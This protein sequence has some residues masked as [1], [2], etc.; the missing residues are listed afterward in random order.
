MS[1][2]NVLS[3]TT[4]GPTA[5]R[6]IDLQPAPRYNSRMKLNPS[7]L[8]TALTAGLLLGTVGVSHG[9]MTPVRLRVAYA[10]NPIGID[11]VQPNLSWQAVA[12]TP[13]AMQSAYEILVASSPESLA[14]DRGD[15]WSTGKVES[16]T[17]IQVRYAGR[18][19]ATHARAYWK[20][21]VW[22][23]A[24]D[25]SDWSEPAYWEMG[26]R[27]PDEFPADW[28]GAELPPAEEPPSL[29]GCH[30][31]WHA[32]DA[33]ADGGVNAPSG[34]RMFRRWIEVPEDA[35]ITRARIL[36]DADDFFRLYVNGIQVSSDDITTRTWQTL[37]LID[38]NRRIVPG[39]NLLA[40]HTE[41]SGNQSSAGLIGRVEVDLADGASMQWD[42]DSSWVSLASEP[43][44]W[45]QPA[46]TPAENEQWT[47]AR[48]VA[49]Y[50]DAP[51]GL[52][53]D[54]LKA[55]QPAPHL[56]TEFALADKPVAYATLTATALGVYEC[57]LNGARVGE[58][59]MTPG[60]TDYT[61][62]IQYQAYDVTPL[63]KPGS[64]NAL[65]ALLGDG[66]YVG[67]IAHVGRYQYGEYPLR[68]KAQ[69]RVQY[70]D[71]SE[72]FVRT[73]PDWQAAAGAILYSDM[74][75]GE[76]QDARRV[77]TGWSEAGGEKS[78]GEWQ[79][80]EV[81]TAEQLPVQPGLVAQQCP[82]VR[83]T[84]EVTPITLTEPEPGTWIFD[85]GQNMVGWCRIR[86][87][88]EAGTTITLRHGEMLEADGTLYTENLRGVAQT[89]QFVLKGDSNEEL[90]EPRFTFHGF[91]YVEVTGFPGKPTL[92][93]LVGRVVG[94]D[95]ERTGWFECS[96]PLVNRLFQNILWSQRGNFL[97]IPTDCP[98]RNERMGWTGDA[99][100]FAP[101]A[102]YNFDCAAFYNKYLQDVR[103]AQFENGAYPV[104]APQ[105]AG[106]GGG[107]NAW[108][109]AGVIVPWVVYQRYGDLAL[110]AEHFDSMTAWIEFQRQN[111][112]GLIRPDNGFG[113]WLSVGADTPK[114]VMNTAYFAYTTR[115]VSEMAR[116]LGRDADAERYA[117][118][119]EEIRKAFLDKFVQPDGTIH[120]DTQAVYVLALKFDLLPESLRTAAADK[121]VE[122]IAEKEMHLSTGFVGTGHLNNVLT[123]TGHT[124]VAYTLLCQ[125]TYPSWLYPVEQGA[126]TI[127][128]RWN[129]WTKESG[130][131]DRSMNSFNHYSLGAV[132]QWL[133]ETVGGIQP[134]EPG[135]KR[136]KIQ[137]EPGDGLSW[138][139]AK[140]NSPYGT[141]QTEWK[142]T[143]DEIELEIEIP[144][145]T[146][147][148]IH[149]TDGKILTRGSGK[150]SLRSTT[151][152]AAAQGQ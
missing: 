25:V 34:A 106:M 99:Q 122:R 130:F 85:L 108:G 95:V 53:D 135:F 41:N 127:W 94:S 136:I 3:P 4:A 83:I 100:V 118:L 124:D 116:L 67:S 60:W 86:A 109:D 71:G 120:G 88:G 145:N 84:G 21:R 35:R 144:A 112:D 96:D 14:A 63:L 50:G 74:Q 11:Q 138:A 9:G 30:W 59:V 152:R 126:T 77:L 89:D 128:E 93:S 78:S 24:G 70:A 58:D 1:P 110:L 69:L 46:Y 38:L 72:Q 91:R 32:G 82:P 20:V 119:Y 105:V 151:Q 143:G 125:R 8:I 68:F 150:H 147:A 114:P 2:P 62:R 140:Y 90:F 148:E 73:G 31:M 97:S 81:F 137:I 36:I 115:L 79:P 22:D 48:A 18:P 149:L 28:I 131:G 10:H 19:V 54:Q 133:F 123:E 141:I 55:M 103:D 57:Y 129:S 142:K 132:G 92:D 37:N 49:A 75:A 17:S 27:T 76:K 98:Q 104:V 61:K 26:P 80:V 113:D 51:W 33:A 29:H 139:K 87:K 47:P 146:E 44:D 16:G 121:L 6:R 102:C 43:A 64:A 101:A 7:L 40:V 13:N 117:T 65:G 45:F 107:V 134:L 111:S 42:I 12:D 23:E 56:R 5:D 39:R 66:W 52:L 15:L